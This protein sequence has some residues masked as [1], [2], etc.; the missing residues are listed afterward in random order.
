MFSLKKVARNFQQQ[1]DNLNSEDTVFKI[2]TGPP[3]G[4]SRWRRHGPHYMAQQLRK[5]LRLSSP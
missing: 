1:Q 4:P 5:P 3:A 2:S